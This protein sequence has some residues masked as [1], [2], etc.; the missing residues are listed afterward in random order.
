MSRADPQLLGVDKGG[1]DEAYVFTIGYI[2]DKG[3]YVHDVKCFYNPT[4]DEIDEWMAANGFF[5]LQG[6]PPSDTQE[7]PTED[8]QPP[9]V[10]DY[11]AITRSVSGG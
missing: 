8:E 9:K 10:V 2:D 6:D 3:V 4:P 11:S 1:P 5:H 7:T